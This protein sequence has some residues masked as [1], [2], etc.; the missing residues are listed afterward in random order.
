MKDS[1][2]TAPRNL[3]RIKCRQTA[4]LG[5]R[6]IRKIGK[7]I[8]GRPDS[9]SDILIYPEISSKTELRDIIN[10]IAWYLPS[11]IIPAHTIYVPLSQGLSSGVP[12]SSPDSQ[13][14]YDRDHL[15][16]VFIASEQSSD[17]VS[18]ADS[19]LCHSF[20]NSLGQTLL[21]N[22][23]RVEIID[24]EFYSTASCSG[25]ITVTTD[26][27]QSPPGVSRENFRRLEE[28]VSNFNN[29]FVFA[30]GPSLEEAY[31]FDFPDN[32]LKVIC[33]SIVRNEAMLD[34]IDP[35]VLVFADP[36]FHFGPS[37][38]A[39]E[40]RQDA[41]EV[42]RNYDCVAAVTA[43]K[44]GLLAGHY[45]DIAEQVIEFKSV[46]SDLPRFP[47]H[48]SLDVMGTANIMTLLMLPIASSLTDRIHIIGADGREEDES[49]FWEHSDIAQYDDDMMKTAVVSHPSF[50]RDRIYTDYYDQ[51]IQTLET[52][53]A[54]GERQGLEYI[55]LTESYI[56]CLQN[57][58]NPR[59]V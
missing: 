28:K 6:A 26:L 29:S 23:E 52:M 21:R 48:R 30:T 40:F 41:A 43:P 39:H 3:F 15:N 33:N 14:M 55:S 38:Y 57:R 45:P 8:F 44:S 9:V 47:T 17:T 51:H 13:P 12:T 5:F 34:H 42:L 32:S 53:I 24:K 27:R 25:W 35:D 16:I 50:F 7:K 54:Y 22:I 18:D 58:Y 36:V 37:R 59:R 4:D 20:Y 19:I 56:E 1:I 2:A 10:R 49:Y 46:G 11:E 31:S